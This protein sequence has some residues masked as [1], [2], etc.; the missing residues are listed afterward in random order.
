MA[1]TVKAYAISPKPFNVGRIRKNIRQV[2]RD[3]GT[4]DKVT[5]NKTIDGWDGEKPTM[6][7]EAKI[8]AGDAFVW[9]GPKGSQSAIEKWR[10]I[11]EPGR[12]KRHPISARRAPY[13]RFP[14]Q[15]LRSSYDAKTT[16]RKFSSS[17]PGKKLGTTRQVKTVDHPGIYEPRE[18]SITLA[19]QRIKPF[20]EAVQAAINKALRIK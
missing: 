18:W 15:G 17:G 20:A 11:D 14:W 8:T 13:L 4:K 19:N 12:A 1:F 5:L 9:I 3:E 6:A 7:Y 16:P 2:L 10:R